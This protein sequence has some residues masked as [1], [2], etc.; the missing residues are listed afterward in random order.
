MF[1]II[2]SHE[3]F[4]IWIGEAGAI[5]HNILDKSSSV[6]V[7]CN[8]PIVAFEVAVFVGCISNYLEYVFI[9]IKN[10]FPSLGPI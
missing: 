5:I 3:F 8:F 10:I 6:K 4:N 1:Y 2:I 7:W 9:M